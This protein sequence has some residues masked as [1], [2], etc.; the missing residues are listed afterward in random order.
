MHLVVKT[1]LI[2]FSNT[3]GICV[4]SNYMPTLTAG[5]C[6]LIMVIPQVN[7]GLLVITNII[8]III[9]HNKKII[10]CSHKYMY[11]KDC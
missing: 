7:I 9:V 5:I 10:S 8:M 3:E 4:V 11:Y 2:L 6:E 1:N